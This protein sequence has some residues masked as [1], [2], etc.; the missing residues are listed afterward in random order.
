[1]TPPPHHVGRLSIGIDLPD[2]DLAFTLRS[3]IE[4]MVQQLLPPVL[5]RVMDR[6]AEGAGHLVIDRLDLDLGRFNPDRLEEE[7]PAAL[8]RALADT[9]ARH[10][11]GGAAAPSRRLS[12]QEALL[13]QLDRWLVTGMLPLGGP[14]D[15]PP[16][17]LFAALADTAPR[18]VVALLLRR[19]RQPR[20]L[21][22][23][24][25]QLGIAGLGRVL[26]L[27]APG[28]A[29]IIRAWLLDLVL[30]H[31]EEPLLS[32]P[33]QA[34]ERLLWLLTLE[35]LVEEAGSQFNRRSYLR[36]LLSRFAEAEHLDYG[37]LLLLL[38]RAVTRL[39]RQR[40][41]GSSLPAVLRDLLGE[42][43][44]PDVAGLVGADGL[45]PL[46]PGPT[47]EETVLPLLLRRA[48]RDPA[49][50]AQF[51]A[52][53]PADR[54]S[55]L[56]HRLEP[57]H[58]GPIL[59]FLGDLAHIQ[60][61]EAVL[62]MSEEGFVRLLRLLTLADLARDHGS[63]FNRRS[64]VRRLL[65]GLADS[66]KLDWRLLLDL[67]RRAVARMAGRGALPPALPGLIGELLAG[68]APE[69]APASDDG[70]G[71]EKVGQAAEPPAEALWRDLHRA[72][73]QR[74]HLAALV[75]R[76]TR[77]DFAFL[78]RRLEPE[79]GERVV[80]Y[81]EA[82]TGLQERE[83][84]LPLPADRFGRLAR[85]LTL[86]HLLRDPGGHF[87]RRSWLRTLLEGLAE[88]EGV[89]YRT[90]LLALAAAVTRTGRQ[91]FQADTLPGLIVELAAEQGPPP[92]PPGRA[93][94]PGGAGTDEREGEPSGTG[95][96]RRLDGIPASRWQAQ[97]NRLA[98]PL[99]TD[100]ALLVDLLTRALPAVGTA[101]GAFAAGRLRAGLLDWLARTPPAGRHLRGAAAWLLTA[102]PGLPPA[103]VPALL[104]Q[105]RHLAAA[106]G[107]PALAA[108]LPP[109]SPPRPARNPRRTLPAAAEQDVQSLIVENAGL[110]LAGPFLPMLFERAQVLAPP[111]DGKPRQLHQDHVSRAVHLLQYL[112]D[113]RWDRPEPALVL[114]KLLCGLHPADPVAAAV[115]PD[116]ADIVLGEGLLSAML[117]QWTILQ[118]SDIAA[119]RETFLQRPGKLE[120]RP[121]GVVLTVQRK[122]LDVL[123]DRIPWGF[124]ILY[125]PWMK[126][127]VHVRW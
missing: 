86:A 27:L 122:T 79:G 69:T 115:S 110:V 47:A 127:P 80:G 49:L 74:T 13:E 84:P 58:A 89:E 75:H 65:R 70:P 88:S 72:G 43:A 15:R 71:T 57:A 10:A 96:F 9:L 116:P 112:V 23:L 119:L 18:A 32:R 73:R 55:R 46:P 36:S 109:A 121:E 117:A 7:V 68:E 104:A 126:E 63:R 44:G 31:R 106:A 95:R 53:L 6:V 125:H 34:V 81:V 62:D 22:R 40:P 77:T 30:L 48:A 35:Y 91:P 14:Q 2:S 105:A 85:T 102:L 92:S 90:V 83:T 93:V 113:A 26:A 67:L 12:P 61:E 98:A 118:G 59:T 21:E 114:N 24:V 4:R 120:W 56:L 50:L 42:E 45:P 66:E 123:V 41:L 99:A 37:A 54:F 78:V 52:R 111:A 51:T 25:L 39:A 8:E 11:A 87:N 5:E 20:V 97:L 124:S 108:A 16:P 101:A 33:E 82:L 29:A 17:A 107:I 64:F 94:A 100:L 1:M 60:R 19:G 28:D 76:L 38:G 103:A 3:R